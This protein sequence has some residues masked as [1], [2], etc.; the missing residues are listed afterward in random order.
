MS[1]GKTVFHVDKSFLNVESK[2]DSALWSHVVLQH[3]AEMTT[4]PQFYQFLS[5]IFHLIL[6][7][8]H[9]PAL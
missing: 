1:Q 8:L 3:I 7:A 9:F 6:L 5:V 2:G 4:Q